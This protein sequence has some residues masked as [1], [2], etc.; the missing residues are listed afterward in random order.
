MHTV[1]AIMRSLLKFGVS[2]KDILLIAFYTVW[3]CCWEQLFKAWGMSIWNVMMKSVNTSC[4]WQPP[5][6]ILDCMTLGGVR[7]PLDFL[8][9]EKHLNMMLSK[10]EDGLIIM[11][12]KEMTQ[13]QCSINSVQAWMSVINHTFMV[14]GGHFKTFKNDT[15]IQMLL[16]VPEFMY[17]KAPLCG[18]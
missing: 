2:A 16:K 18:V 10:A 15:E 11:N 14:G 3:R 6:V 5:F 8:K 12:S 9:N 17:E 13:K 1:N 4:K 7:H